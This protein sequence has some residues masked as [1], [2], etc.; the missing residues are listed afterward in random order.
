MSYE[1]CIQI[2]FVNR[3][4]LLVSRSAYIQ[5]FPMNLQWRWTLFGNGRKI[6]IHCIRHGEIHS[7]SHGLDFGAQTV[8]PNPIDRETLAG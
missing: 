8:Q 6:N 4:C 3:R 5:F 1:S 2:P 7:I